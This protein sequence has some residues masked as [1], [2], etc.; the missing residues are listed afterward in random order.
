MSLPSWLDLKTHQSQ[1]IH[2]ILP[3]QNFQDHFQD[4]VFLFNVLIWVANG[5]WATLLS[6]DGRIILTDSRTPPLLYI[7]W[8]IFLMALI[9]SLR[10]VVSTSVRISSL[11][12]LAR[13]CCVSV[14]DFPGDVDL[15]SS[16]VAETSCVKKDVRRLFFT[17]SLAPL[18]DIL[19]ILI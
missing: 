5:E 1:K 6:S 11:R 16:S 4:G 18:A 12:D 3:L 19:L 13:M 17:L 9:F 8:P 10:T 14:P 2:L 15:G 7:M